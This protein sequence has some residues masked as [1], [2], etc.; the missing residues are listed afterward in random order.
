MTNAYR[1]IFAAPGAKA[2]SSAGLLARLPLPLTHMGILTMLSETTGEYALAGLVAG[3][4]TFSMAF[5]GP[6][7]SKAVDRRGQSRVLPLATGVSLLGLAALLICA[8]TGAPDWTLFLCALV[9][10]LMPSMSAMVR[11]RWTE[12]YRGTP[13]LTTAYSMESVV[14]ELTYVIGPAL[15]VVLSTALFPQAAPLF[16]GLLLLVGVALFVPQKRTE[17]PVKP[18]SDGAGGAS[19]IRSA[20]VLLLAL[21]LLC[22]GAVPGMVDT[23]GL[24]FAAEQGDKSL[25][26]LVFAVYAIGSGLAGLLFGAR[27]PD[28]PLPRLLLAG[29]GGTALTTLPF[30]FVDG[31]AGMVAAVFLAGVFFAPTMVVIMGIV[32]R[33]TPDYQLTEAMTWMIAGLQSGV[34]IGAAVSGVVYDRFGATAGVSVALVAGATALLLTLCALPM[35]RTR[36]TASSAGAVSSAHTTAPAGC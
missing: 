6:Q 1:E 36:L 31:V 24:A 3:A 15:A 4:F 35:L 20:P 34:A 25:A 18:R 16:A 33:V 30:L 8:T 2:F 28:V 12:I 7:V 10:G 5:L 11:A 27:Q 21:V 23:M 19:A 32:E 22:G 9:S 14:D 17:P 13:R 29:V 26:G